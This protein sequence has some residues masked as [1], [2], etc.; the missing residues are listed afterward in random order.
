MIIVRPNKTTLSESHIEKIRQ[1]KLGKPR[2]EETK[3]KIKDGHARRKAL[4]QKT[5]ATQTGS[6]GQK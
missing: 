4:R 1:S 6:E 5:S 3:Q 2:S